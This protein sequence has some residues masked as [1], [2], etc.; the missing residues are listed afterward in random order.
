MFS[1]NENSGDKTSRIICSVTQH[2]SF[3]QHVHSTED[4]ATL[5][6]V[7]QSCHR[8]HSLT[9][10]SS[11]TAS[12]SEESS[13]NIE[14]SPSIGCYLPRSRPTS[15]KDGPLTA[16]LYLEFVVPNP[17]Q[18]QIC[19]ES[20]H[21]WR[22]GIFALFCQQEKRK[23]KLVLSQGFVAATWPACSL[24]WASRGLL[25]CA[26]HRASLLATGY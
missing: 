23:K 19:S 17:W 15:S 25:S 12:I 4:T 6:S 21:D 9:R 7:R 11:N 1:S 24:D 13:L 20:C 5:V 3:A 8:P 26:P 18:D 16:L 14:Y 2:V 10:H 22:V